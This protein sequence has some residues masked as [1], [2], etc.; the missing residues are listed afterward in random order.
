MFQHFAKFLLCFTLLLSTEQLLYAATEPVD[1]STFPIEQ[2]DYDQ[3]VSVSSS[4]FLLIDL[5]EDDYNPSKPDFVKLKTCYKNSV[6]HYKCPLQKTADHTKP[7]C[8]SGKFNIPHH[9][10]D[11][12]DPLS[13]HLG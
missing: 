2:V 9:N 1:K 11:K 5:T 10:Q 6:A 7:R 12:E 3:H 4:G 13:F 8:V